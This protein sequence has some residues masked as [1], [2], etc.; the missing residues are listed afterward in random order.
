MK[1][2]ILAAATTLSLGV[3][4]AF[5]P[6]APESLVNPPL[7]QAWTNQKLAEQAAQDRAVAANHSVNPNATRDAR[8]SNER[9]G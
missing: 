3:G 6:G 7:G 5:A 9:G 1:T 8:L 4:A 2:L